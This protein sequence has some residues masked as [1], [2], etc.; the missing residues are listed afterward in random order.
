[1]DELPA[2]DPGPTPSAS[3]QVG[4]FSVIDGALHLEGTPVREAED[5]GDFNTHPNGH[6]AWWPR[7]VTRLNPLRLLSYDDDPRGRVNY[8]KPEGRSQPS[9]DRCL[10]HPRHLVPSMLQRLH[11]VDQAVAML[12][13]EHDQCAICNPDSV[14]D[15]I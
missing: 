5:Y 8:A 11:L 15:V 1:M 13:D 2:Q 9:L 12:T 3:P 6:L 4:I 7:L 14:P 10:L